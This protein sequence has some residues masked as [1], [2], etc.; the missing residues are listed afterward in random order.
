MDS[1]NLVFR[2]ITYSLAERTLIMAALNITP[3]SFSDGG[4]YLETEK[5]VE[6]GLRLT[7]AGADILDLGGESTRPGSPPLAEEEELRRLIPAI[8]KLRQQIDIPISVDTRKAKVA[9]K[10]IDEGAEIINDISAL[11]FDPEMARVVAK[12]KVYIVLMHMQGEPET[13]QNHPHY[14]DL[15]GE[16]MGFFQERLSFAISQEIP[17]ERIILDPGLG[18]GKSVEEKHNLRLLKGLTRF[19]SLGQPLLVGPSR[20][21]FIGRILNLPPSEREEGTMGAVAVAI[22]NGAHIVRVHEVARM[23]R[24]I[25]VVDAVVHCPAES[26]IPENL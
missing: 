6:Q 1:L 11:R 7:A 8:R 18:F 4:K 24:L 5:A 12:A 2:N 19:K 25:R 15:M 21:S 14:G 23:S 9:E 13:M 10:V 20:K 16:V 26:A 17:R 3:D 22:M